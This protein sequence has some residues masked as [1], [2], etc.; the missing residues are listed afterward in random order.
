M[1]IILLLDFL[2]VNFV[3]CHGSQHDFN[4]EKGKGGMGQRIKGSG[5]A[6]NPRGV[7][8]S[9]LTGRADPSATTGLILKA[10]F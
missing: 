5:R 6:A 9:E 3:G 10:L 8:G 7:D 4:Q 1:H 2:K